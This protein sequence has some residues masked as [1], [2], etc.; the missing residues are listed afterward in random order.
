[1]IVERKKERKKRAYA[2]N[3]FLSDNSKVAVEEVASTRIASV[4]SFYKASPDQ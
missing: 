1:V 3:S 2:G 4:V